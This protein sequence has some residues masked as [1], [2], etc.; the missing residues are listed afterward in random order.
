MAL[1]SRRRFPFDQ[2][3]IGGGSFAVLAA[4]REVQHFN[5]SNLDKLHQQQ[6]ERRSDYEGLLKIKYANGNES[7]GKFGNALDEEE[8]GC[9]GYG[10]VW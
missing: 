1:V 2:A 3:N 7:T 6:N 8:I 10:V 9:G 4:A 5:N